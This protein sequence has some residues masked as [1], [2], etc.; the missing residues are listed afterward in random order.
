[1]DRRAVFA[2]FGVVLAVSCLDAG[3]AVITEAVVAVHSP[4]IAGTVY[5]TDLVLTN[6]AFGAGSCTL[7]LLDPA[8]PAATGVV[9]PQGEDVLVVEDVYGLLAPGVWGRAGLLVECV[10]AV[11]VTSRTY[12]ESDLDGT[13]TRGQNIHGLGPAGQLFPSTPVRILGVSENAASRSNLFLINAGSV[14]ATVRTTRDADGTTVDTPVPAMSMVEVPQVMT[15]FFGVTNTAEE[16]LRFET[17]AGGPIVALV[18][19][20]ETASADT[21][22]LAAQ[23]ADGTTGPLIVPA[24]KQTD[25]VTHLDL[26]NPGVSSEPVTLGFSSGASAVVDLS[27]GATS[28]ADVLGTLGVAAGTGVL[29][30][31]SANPILGQGRYFRSGVEPFIAA[32]PARSTLLSWYVQRAGAL[33]GV[34]RATTIVSSQAAASGYQTM[35]PPSS[36]QPVPGSCSPYAVAPGGAAVRDWSVAPSGGGSVAEFVTDNSVQVTSFL[37]STRDSNDL[38]VTPLFGSSAPRPVVQQVA[39]DCVTGHATFAARPD[40]GGLTWLWYADGVSTGLATKTIDATPGVA[41]HVV[42][43]DPLFPTP[44]QSRLASVIVPLFCDG[45]E[46]GGTSAWGP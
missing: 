2:G 10:T 12:A 27:P 46:S 28:L 22:T 20:V 5:K 13:D 32:L 29:K 43:T 35:L 26:F 17:S 19:L 9:V 41:Y 44:G 37:L 11:E 34:S 39:Y 4:G 14:A 33:T 6:L 30:I 23:P 16:S 36:P 24:L 31:T 7:T 25:L 40:W 8:H 38:M 45:F 21:A 42:V 3:A 1:M 18:S 15:V